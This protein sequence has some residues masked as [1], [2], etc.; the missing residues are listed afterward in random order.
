MC[1][2]NLHGLVAPVSLSNN[3]I[4]GEVITG[5]HVEKVTLILFFKIRKHLGEG[6]I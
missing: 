4:C 3:V 2:Q 6:N 1:V 5:K